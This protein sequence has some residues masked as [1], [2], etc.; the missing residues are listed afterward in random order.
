MQPKHPKVLVVEP[1]ARVRATLVQHLSELRITVVDVPDGAS[2]L[3]V[4]TA[5]PTI[6]VVVT[7]L[8]LA[9]GDETCLTRAIR[10]APALQLTRVVVHTAHR[11]REA[12][13]WARAVGVH[14]LLISPTLPERLRYVVGRLLTAS[15]RTRPGDSP[16]GAVIRRASLGVAL[17]EI[18]GGRLTG[19]SCI[20]FNLSWWDGLTPRERNGYRRRSKSAGVALRTN[21]VMTA[22]FV[23][24][25]STAARQ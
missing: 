4:L 22:H 25:R 19:S 8:Y 24:V 16:D 1:N 15:Q 11:T 3:K 17:E 2:A 5:E 7:N 12:Q 10:K 6:P 13:D 20:V 18:E 9:A 23:E 21:P 14:G